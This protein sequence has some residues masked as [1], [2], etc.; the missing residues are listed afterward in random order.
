MD[1]S[2]PTMDE[3]AV[4]WALAFLLPPRRPDA[5]GAASS[6]PSFIGLALIKCVSNSIPLLATIKLFETMHHDEVFVLILSLVQVEII[7][8]LQEKHH[9]SK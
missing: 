6:G 2:M 5:A 4:L 3:L 1:T 8:Q 9:T 7:K